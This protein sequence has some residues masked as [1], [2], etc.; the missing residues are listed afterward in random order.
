[1]V[2]EIKTQF[3][4]L[5][6]YYKKGNLKFM[7]ILSEN[8]EWNLAY[9]K[10]LF[11]NE[12]ITENNPLIRKI[13]YKGV[14]FLEFEN[15]INS[16]TKIFEQIMENRKIQIEDTFYSLG[17]KF[18]F[19]FIPSYTSYEGYYA[20]FPTYQ[21]RIRNNDIKIHYKE[22]EL[23]ALD[24]PF[25]PSLSEGANFFFDL[26][27]TDF[28]N[29]FN[30]VVYLNMPDYS[31]KIEE[32]RIS[33]KVLKFKIYKDSSISDVNDYRVKLYYRT[34]NNERNSVD[35]CSNGNDGIFQ[36][37]VEEIFDMFEGVL[38]NRQR[39]VDSLKY[40]PNRYYQERTYKIFQENEK[41]YLENMIS[42]GENL[43]IEFKEKYN[44][45]KREEFLETIIAFANTNGG[46]LF[47]G[48]ND[49]G[50]VVGTNTMRNCENT[51]TDWIDKYCIPP[52]KAEIIEETLNDQKI[53]I[54]KINEGDNKP[55]CLLDTNNR[56]LF[57]VR[58]GSTDR[59]MKREEIEEIYRLK[60]EDRNNIY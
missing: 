38:I 35:L 20:E 51:I 24:S 14:Q 40:Y 29:Q 45:N 23:F 18:E 21:I 48:I 44:T 16:F 55:Y 15:E 22:D 9:C 31:A 56:H 8:D 47:L 34:L 59:L 4:L 43:T 58:R 5:N 19:R 39:K 41:L 7:L 36:H 13:E 12:E 60:Y 46:T 2:E 17:N 25:F 32:V 57:Y 54:V 49:N 30:P 3:R 53:I 42:K 26:Q 27:K 28:S 11:S 6:N 50:E 1:M 33:E 52:I 37:K 10:I